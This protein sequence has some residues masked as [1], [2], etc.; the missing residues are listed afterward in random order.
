VKLHPHQR[1]KNRFGAGVNKAKTAAHTLA[2]QLNQELTEFMFTVETA[3]VWDESDEYDYMTSNWEDIVDEDTSDGDTIH[4][5][6]IDQLLNGSGFP[7]ETHGYGH[8]EDMAALDTDQDGACVSNV[9]ALETFDGTD[10]LK[11]IVIHETLHTVGA[12]HD[13]GGVT[14][15]NNFGYR[16]YNRVSPMA[17]AYVRAPG[18][19][20]LTN[21]D[22]TYAG[23]GHEV[24]KFDATGVQNGKF[25]MEAGGVNHHQNITDE[26]IGAVSEYLESRFED[27]DS[28]SGGG[29]DPCRGTEICITSEDPFDSLLGLS[30]E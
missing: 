11:N 24:N 27:D 30:S 22:T 20:V 13:D 28:G 15:R 19:K 17:T 12:H 26:T 14:V 6:L 5:F 3:D 7:A 29:T 16:R 10:A 18:P 25:V 8:M 1:A 2:D 4:H 23:S 9:G 21:A